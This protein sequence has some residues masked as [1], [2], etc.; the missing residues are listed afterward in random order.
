MMYQLICLH[1]VKQR[2]TYKRTSQPHEVAWFNPICIVVVAQAVESLLGKP[3]R[4]LEGKTLLLWEM[5]IIY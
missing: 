5:K 1:L 3:G 2:L 4:N